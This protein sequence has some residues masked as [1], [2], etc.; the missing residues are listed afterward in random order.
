MATKPF[1]P[2]DPDAQ[3]IDEDLPAPSAWF[4]TRPGETV[5]DPHARLFGAVGPDLGYVGTL[6]PSFATRL[7]PGAAD[8]GDVNAAGAAVA[9]AR[10][11][12]FG[13][14]P[15]KEDCEVAFLLLGVLEDTPGDWADAGQIVATAIEGCRHDA[16]RAEHVASS[17]PS[18]WLR[19]GASAVRDRLAAEGPD[20]VF[21]TFTH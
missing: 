7:V 18:A 5:D 17:I 8:R 12:T 10:A 21:V 4:A 20:D 2:D 16:A 14:G 11:S 9:R 15:V 3:H 19:L 1:V 6:L 13:R